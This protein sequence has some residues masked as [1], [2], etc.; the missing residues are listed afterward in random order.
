[1]CGIHAV[2]INAQKAM[3]EELARSNL[4]SIAEGVQGKGR[5]ARFAGD[6]Q[7]WFA[8]RQVAR[9]EARITGMRWRAT[10]QDND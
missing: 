5:P 3:R 6:V 8:D 10:A 9:E 2:M 1:M 7:E 4:A